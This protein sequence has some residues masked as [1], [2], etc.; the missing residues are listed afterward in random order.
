MILKIHENLKYYLYSLLLASPNFILFW[1]PCWDTHNKI[2]VI[3]KGKILRISSNIC[4][5]GGLWC[6][7]YI[8]LSFCTSM[9]LTVS[10]L[11]PLVCYGKQFGPRGYG[12]GQGGGTLQSDLNSA[13][14]VLTLEYYD[15]S[16]KKLQKCTLFWQS[17]LQINVIKVM[18]KTILCVLK[19][20][21]H[22]KNKQL[23]KTKCDVIRLITT[24]KSSAKLQIQSENGIARYQECVLVVAK[25]IHSCEREHRYSFCY[26]IE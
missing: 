11:S 7:V 25:W 21:N 26:E 16:D 18:S 1:N 22:N 4:I 13:E 9:K 19:I 6:S 17:S 2:K 8:F 14:Y 12:Y 15:P 24:T 3:M 10:V 23:S 20:A 5:V